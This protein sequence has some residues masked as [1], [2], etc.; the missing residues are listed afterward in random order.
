MIYDRFIAFRPYISQCQASARQGLREFA[1]YVFGS[2]ATQCPCLVLSSTFC[3][4]VSLARFGGVNYDVGVVVRA[5]LPPFL[6][7]TRRD[8]RPHLSPTKI[9]Y[10][11]W[12]L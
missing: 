4:G 6:S 1:L 5:F 12:L 3:V 11:F 7:G 10:P 2:D 9:N 8:L